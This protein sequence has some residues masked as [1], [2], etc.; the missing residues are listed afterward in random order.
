MVLWV[1][2][3]IN[4]FSIFCNSLSIYVLYFVNNTSFALFV[5]AEI[6]KLFSFNLSHLGFLYKESFFLISLAFSFIKSLIKSRS[7]NIC[8]IK[9]FKIVEII[10][11]VL[12]VPALPFI[13]ILLKAICSFINLLTLVIQIFCSSL[14][15]NNCI[16][17]F[18]L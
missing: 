8:L 14:G 1:V 3:L 16:F 7:S 13:N 6:T 5:G 9:I 15:L 2:F 11:V 10:I 12:P 18:Y 4:L 17:V